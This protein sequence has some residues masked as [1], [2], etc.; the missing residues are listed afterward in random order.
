MGK[1]ASC[2]HHCTLLVNSN[3]SFLDDVLLSSFGKLIMTKATD[4]VRSQVTNLQLES[5]ERVEGENIFQIVSKDYLSTYNLNGTV[6]F[7]FSDVTEEEILSFPGI[8]E[9]LVKFKILP[10]DSDQ[11]SASLPSDM[12]LYPSSISPEFAKDLPPNTHPVRILH[13]VY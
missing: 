7:S 11:V 6:P 12:S 10:I 4:S 2:Y 3:L 13:V 1:E 9:S 5:H 8:E